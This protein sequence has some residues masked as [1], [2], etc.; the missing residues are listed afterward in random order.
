[1][2]VLVWGI[3]QGG[4]AAFSRIRLLGCQVGVDLWSVAVT[5]TT[6]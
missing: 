3:T 6:R 5:W 4:C 2:G 1:M